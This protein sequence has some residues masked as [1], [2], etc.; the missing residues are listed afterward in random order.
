MGSRVTDTQTPKKSAL[1]SQPSPHA[2]EVAAVYRRRR[3]LALL[4]AALA[5][6]TL[7]ALAYRGGRYY[8]LDPGGRFA[9]P[10]DRT[11]R[12]SGVWGHGVGI[13]ATLVML[14]NFLYPLRK[15]A[16]WMGRTGSVPMWLIFHVSVGLMTPLV[17]L[18]HAAFRFNNLIAT[19]SYGS[20]IVVVVTGLI[21]RYIYSMVP[22]TSG[23]R[24]GELQD[25][26]RSWVETV[27][28]V[29]TDLG[30]SASPEWLERL[31]TPPIP[32]RETS[33]ARAFRAVLEW[34]GS[35]L[36]ARSGARSLA[37]RLPHDRG[38]DLTTAVGQ[39]VRLRLQI[40]FFGGIK[41]LLATWRFG[42]SLLA[43]FLVVVI[44]VHVAVSVAFGYRWI[45]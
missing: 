13:V 33:A 24:R 12:P 21:G 5:L 26:Q 39:M 30:E 15:R 41:R 40:E 37:R 43:F 45:F 23:L 29:R 38:R 28:G 1:P 42:H 31:L 9:H 16:Q 44:I 36:R 7:T 4:L 25:L 19:F 32:A 14:M 18:F 10:Q 34:P 35:A 11:L 17:I 6:L 8:T 3:N 22:G 2:A 27:A 20:L